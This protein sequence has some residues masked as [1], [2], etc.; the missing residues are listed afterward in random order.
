MA[1]WILGDTH[2]DMEI[3]KIGASAVKDG[4]TIA[5]DDF[6]IVCGD[7]GFPFLD[8]DYDPNAARSPNQNERS[9]RKTYVYW[10]KWMAEKPYN[11]LFVAGNHD[12]HP[13]WSRLPVE[14]WHGGR[15]HRSPDAP[16]VIHLM[17]GEIFELEGHSF[18]AFGGAASH[19]KGFRI[20][21]VNWWPTEI[22]DTAT[23]LH[24]IDTLRQHGN[25]VDYILT[26]TMPRSK[27]SACGINRVFHDPVAQYLDGIYGTV[28][29]QK[30]FCGHFHTDVDRPD[31]RIRVLYDQFEVIGHG[32]N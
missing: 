24:G 25:K 23:M 2:G 16:N 18:W 1:I 9:A 28:E 20:E 7:F 3:R 32:R 5:A 22:P 15:I 30:W 4:H 13:Y 11:I 27:I 14:N 10:M 19:D 12:N 21:G 8:C 26:H 6:V 31:L 17:D 29:F